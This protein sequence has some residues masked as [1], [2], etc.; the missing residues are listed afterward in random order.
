MYHVISLPLTS[1]CVKP[2]PSQFQ[3]FLLWY[4]ISK[5]SGRGEEIISILNSSQTTT[6]LGLIEDLT[7]Y[8]ALVPQYSITFPS[9]FP[10]F[11]Y[12]R[13][14]SIEGF[15]AGSYRKDSLACRGFK[16][17]TGKTYPASTGLTPNRALMPQVSVC[18]VLID[19]ISLGRKAFQSLNLQ[20]FDPL[21]MVA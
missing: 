21:D 5:S 20:L 3:R 14:V 19:N 16:M 2:L 11:I 7:Y 8:C 13:S 1:L 18:T 6:I 15:H 10:P 17:C 12:M 9:I 4:L